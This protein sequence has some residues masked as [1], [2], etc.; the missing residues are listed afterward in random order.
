MYS[1]L[2]AVRTDLTTQ[3]R[4]FRPTTCCKPEMVRSIGRPIIVD[5]LETARLLVFQISASLFA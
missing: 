5:S 3:C 2:V 1:Q 4:D